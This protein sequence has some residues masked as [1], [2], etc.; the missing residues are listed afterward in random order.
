MN[1]FDVQLH[2]PFNLLALA[3]EKLSIEIMLTSS[4]FLS[5]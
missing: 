1:V 3:D 4:I 2:L 5:H